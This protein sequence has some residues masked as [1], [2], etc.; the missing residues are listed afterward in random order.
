MST[1]GVSP[2]VR[3]D[4]AVRPEWP[5]RTYIPAKT[6]LRVAVLTTM[7]SRDVLGRGLRVLGRAIRTEPRLFAVGTA[8]SSLFGLLVIANSYLVGGVIG[9]VVVPAFAEHR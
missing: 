4:R 1:S 8:G 2:A 9:N 5:A 3:Q 6:Y 7:A